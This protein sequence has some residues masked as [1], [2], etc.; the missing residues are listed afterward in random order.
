MHILYNIYYKITQQKGFY[1]IIYYIN[2][3]EHYK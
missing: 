1:V 3:R 2:S